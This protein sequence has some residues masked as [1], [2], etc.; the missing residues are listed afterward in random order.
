MGLWEFLRQWRP[1]RV[2]VGVVASILLHLAVVAIVLWGG[3][4]L[5]DS[6][7]KAKKGDALIV[8][9]PKPEEPAPAGTPKAAIA[10]P[11]PPAPPSLPPSA[12]RPAPTPPAVQRAPAP[13][14]ERRVASA[15]RSP[16]PAPPAPRPADPG[17][18]APPTREAP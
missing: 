9:L 14:E 12:P 5:P 1:S 8:E 3:K 16:A 15:P 17:T 4:I 2:T 10:P 6:R 7:W 11:A 18:S 13:P